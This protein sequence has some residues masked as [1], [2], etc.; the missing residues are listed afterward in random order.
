MLSIATFPQSRCFSLASE[1][2]SAQDVDS[3]FDDDG[4]GLRT[5]CGFGDYISCD[6]DTG[7]PK[8][9]GYLQVRTDE[10]HCLNA[11]SDIYTTI[12]T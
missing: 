4:H 5:I 12:Y 2:T 6:G 10:T 9:V 1:G 3:F 11:L 7:R 8:A